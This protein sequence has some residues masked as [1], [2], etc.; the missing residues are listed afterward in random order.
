MY[1]LT[2]SRVERMAIDWIGGRYWNGQILFKL[3]W[4][5]CQPHDGDLDWDS[6]RDITFAVPEWVA[7]EIQSHYEEEGL[8]CFSPWVVD[9]FQSF[10]GSIV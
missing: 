7:W 1:S 9:N 4:G 10:L 8:P 2:L 6:P 3:L 5:H